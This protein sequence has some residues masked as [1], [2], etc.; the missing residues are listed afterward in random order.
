M[1]DFPSP[2]ER[3]YIDRGGSERLDGAGLEVEP[4]EQVRRGAA[5]VGGARAHVREWGEIGE[6]FL[7]RGDQGKF[8]PGLAAQVAL[9]PGGAFRYRGHTAQRDTDIGDL[10]TVEAQREGRAT[11]EMSWS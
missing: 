8:V 9:G 3:E 4:L 7:P 6:D 5:A 10:V 2:A 1:P 11:A